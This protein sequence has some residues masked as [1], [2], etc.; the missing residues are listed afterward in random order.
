MGNFE[1]L[2]DAESEYTLSVSR[3]AK[4]CGTTRDTLRYYYEQKILTPRVDESNGY[5]YYSTSQITSFFF[6]TTMRQAGCSIKEISDILYHSSRSSISKVVNSKIL[7]MQRQLYLMNIKISA[8]HLGMW[9]LEGYEYQ[10]SG[11]PFIDYLPEISVRSTPVSHPGSYH[12]KDIAGDISV[13]LG[14]AQSDDT[15]FLFPTG[16]TISS[17]NLL[18]GDYTYN[19]IISLSFLPSDN[20][21]TYPIPGSMAIICYHDHHCG[22]IEKTYKKIVSIM[23]K[24]RLKACSDLYI[25][26]LINLYDTEANHKYFKYLFICVK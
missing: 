14:K 16:V 12:T 10:K 22:S 19:N 15:L 26:S 8:L 13:H 18:M 17:E 5:H 11:T 24:N 9:I 7:D 23:K 3:F 6:I 1:N 20:S 25:I 21:E 2:N 4:L